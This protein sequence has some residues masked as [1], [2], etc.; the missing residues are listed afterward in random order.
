MKT[1]LHVILFHVGLENFQYFVALVPTIYVDQLGLFSSYIITNQ[2]AVTEFSRE[3]DI[4][5]PDNAP[6]VF[7]KYDIEPLSVRI[8]AKR[9]GI[10]Q[11]TTRLCGVFGGVFVVS[12]LLLRLYQNIVKYIK[13]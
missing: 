7:I 5:H 4:R 6:G 10:I 2:Y 12:G 13:L 9:L 3:I 8:T 1:L 11:F